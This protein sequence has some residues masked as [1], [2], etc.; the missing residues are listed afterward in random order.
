[1]KVSDDVRQDTELRRDQKIV[2]LD[3][4]G[5]L[6]TLPERPDLEDLG[7]LS[8]FSQ[9]AV[10]RLNQICE[11]EDA[12]VVISSSWRLVLNK[13]QILKRLN[14]AG[15]RG[16]LHEDW[17]TPDIG[18][19]PRGE[20]I[21]AWLLEHRDEVVSWVILD[22]SDDFYPYQPLVQ[23]QGDRGLEDLH[24]PEACQLLRGQHRH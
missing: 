20:E 1:M 8:S 6:A 14:D 4:D 3:F 18:Q 5:V 23:T 2:F 15:F 21:K 16:A 10:E 13:R 11:G 12:K 7:R 19:K 22:D 17:L 24:V 9:D